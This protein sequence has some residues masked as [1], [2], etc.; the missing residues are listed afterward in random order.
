MDKK[1]TINAHRRGAKPLGR[2]EKSNPQKDSFL[3][4]K[5]LPKNVILD[6]TGMLIPELE[7]PDQS[8]KIRRRIQEGIEVIFSAKPKEVSQPKKTLELGE[9]DPKVKE[10]ILKSI[11]HLR[12]FRTTHQ[13][14]NTIDNPNTN[15]SQLSKLII[16]DPV[17]SGRILKVANSAYFG[18]QQRVNSIGHALMI[19]G[20]LNLKNILYQEELLKLLNIKSSIKNDMVEPLWEHATLTSI[21]ASY[22]H[23]LFSGLDRGVLFTMGLLHDVGKFVMS[24]LNPIRTTGEDFIRISPSE[25]SIYDEDELYGINHAV[26]GRLAFEEWRFS[27]LMVRTVELHHAPSWIEMEALGLDYE[28]LQYLLILF[29]SDQVAKLFAGEEKGIFPIHPLNPS[30]HPFI[31]RKRLLNLILDSSLFSEIKKTKALMETDR[32]PPRSF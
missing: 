24:G 2:G 20:L 8:E 23:P 1:G 14:Y 11:S 31:Q 13:L 3:F 18:M 25:F 12:D 22:I 19:I 6:D 9:I 17:L 16:T 27:E 26:I 7:R 21:C 29:L 32:P 10:V 28:H 4:S 15:M 30:Y 5:N